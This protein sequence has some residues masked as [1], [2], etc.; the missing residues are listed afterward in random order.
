MKYQ[1]CQAPKMAHV[2]IEGAALSRAV[3][4]ERFCSMLAGHAKV[5]PAFA[6]GTGVV[7]PERQIMRVF[8][9]TS[10]EVK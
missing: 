6:M 5:R 2:P 4:F 10:R 7:S 8:W 9:S 3:F 1:A